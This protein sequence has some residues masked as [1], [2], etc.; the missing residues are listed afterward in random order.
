[1]HAL[2]GL[3][4]RVQRVDRDR[5]RRQIR[6]AAPEVDEPR[7]GLRARKRRRGDDPREVLLREA[8][9]ELGTAANVQDV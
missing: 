1:V 8:G 2:R 9:E 3:D 4:R 7:P 6:V 5:G